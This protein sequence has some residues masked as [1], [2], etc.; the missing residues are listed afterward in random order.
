LRGRGETERVQGTVRSLRKEECQGWNASQKVNFKIQINI[1]PKQYSKVSYY[2]IDY[3][4]TLIVD[5]DRTSKITVFY[6]VM[7][8]SNL[9]HAMD[10]F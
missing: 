10:G 1:S 2:K 3:T 9:C 4:V 5:G 6:L 8:N 7:P